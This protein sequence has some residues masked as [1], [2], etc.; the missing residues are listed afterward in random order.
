[1]MA[2]LRRQ[3]GRIAA[4]SNDGAPRCTICLEDFEDGEEVTV[5]PCGR[6]HE[7]HPACITRWL[8]KSN[9]CPLCRHQLPAC[10][11]NEQK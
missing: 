7:F 6:G 1:M 4:R 10:D 5:M 9:M 11:D 8:G 3:R 2:A